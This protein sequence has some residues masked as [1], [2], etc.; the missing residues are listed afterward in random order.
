[1]TRMRTL[2]KI[3]R[4][5]FSNVVRSRWLLPYTGGLALATDLLIRF[6]GTTDAGLLGAG[7]L[8]LL[9]IP[10][11][12]LTV[13]T[14]YFYSSRTFVELMLAQPVP[15]TQLALGLL[16]G[17]ALPLA[18]GFAIG[19][20]VPLSLHGAFIGDT[21]SAAFALLGSGTLLAT[22]FAAIA[23]YISVRIED[24]LR[25][26]ALAIGIWLGLSLL[27]DGVVLMAAM[28]L[29]DY[30]IERPLLATMLLNPVDLARVWLMLQLDVAALLGY[31]GAVLQKFFGS[32]LGALI[33]ATALI[34][35]TAIPLTLAVRRFAR[36]DF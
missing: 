13:G 15:R 31:T 32:G 23:F 12:S 2:L 22:A 18:G 7:N 6:S 33:A 9:I 26:L 5:E 36:R 25:G 21:R 28:L 20:G 3:A 4:Y 10:L 11:V 29:S 34:A 16:I 17:S 27:Y 35:W 14:M 30:P 19:V 24:R 8:V 1:M